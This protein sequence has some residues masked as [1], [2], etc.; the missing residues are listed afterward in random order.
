MLI[1]YLNSKRHADLMLHVSVCVRLETLFGTSRN[2]ISF[3]GSRNIVKWKYNAG[4][5]TNACGFAQL[6]CISVVIS[7]D[8]HAF[9]IHQEINNF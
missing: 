7:L 6:I 9:S 2:R 3:L 5:V 8:Q 1:T 4:Q